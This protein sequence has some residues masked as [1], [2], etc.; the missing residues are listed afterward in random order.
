MILYI[1]FLQVNYNGLN[2]FIGYSS[3][4][5]INDDDDDGFIAAEIGLYYSFL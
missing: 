5:I 2:E 4:R 1:I 3:D